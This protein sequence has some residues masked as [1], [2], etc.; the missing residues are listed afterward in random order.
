MKVKLNNS[1]NVGC[2]I[3]G[4][5]FVVILSVFLAN[6]TG[7]NLEWLVL[8]FGGKVVD[9][10]FILSLVLNI[11]LNGVALA[12]NVVVEILKIIM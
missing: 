11:V 9:I 10:P 7:G 2:G 1:G 3:A 12:F 5:I 4:I 6:W 8:T